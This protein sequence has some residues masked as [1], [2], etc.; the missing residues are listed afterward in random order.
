[1]KIDTQGFDSRVIN[2]AKE[3]LPYVKFVQVEMSLVPLYKDEVLFDKML[4][5]MT[6]NGFQLIAIEPGF[7][8]PVSG[9]TLQIDGIFQRTEM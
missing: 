3:S 1:M 9:H 5:L 6:D 4:E 2:G 7:M 8:D